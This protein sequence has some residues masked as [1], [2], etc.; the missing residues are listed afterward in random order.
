MNIAFLDLIECEIGLPGDI[1]VYRFTG[2]A[3]DEIAVQVN[4]TGGSAAT[5][6]F[7]VRGPGVQGFR[8]NCIPGFLQGPVQRRGFD[9]PHS[10]TYEIRVWESTA[11]GTMAYRLYLD[12]THPPAAPQPV[13][14]NTPVQGRIVHGADVSYFVFTGRAGA[15]IVAQA[16][17]T[18]GEGASPCFELR[19]PGN[20]SLR[21]PC[22]P[23]SGS[24]ASRRFE[25]RLSESG[26][27][28][29]RVWEQN[30]RSPMEYSLL[31]QCFGGCPEDRTQ[32]P[33]Q[34]PFTL[35]WNHPWLGYGHDFGE[36]EWGHDGMITS[37]WTYQVFPDSR[38]ITDTRAVERGGCSGTGILRA[39]LEMRG[40]QPGVDRGEVFL[41]LVNHPPETG[42]YAE[43]AQSLNLD[44][45]RITMRLRLP[46]GSAGSGSAPNGIQF[47]F[48]T[49][50]TDEDYPSLYSPW[51]NV[52][53]AWPGTCVDVSY[54]LTATSAGERTP[55]FDP[56][57]VRLI[58]FKIGVNSQSGA[59]IRGAVDI[60]SFRI[61][62]PPP[63]LPVIWDFEELEI[64]KD[65]RAA[66]ELLAGVDLSVV[67]IFTLADG[68]AAP[69]FNAGAASGF[70]RT[71]FDDFDALLTV[72]ARR[73]VRVMPVLLDFNWFTRPRT[74]SRAQLGGHSD[75]I[76]DPVKLQGFL[77]RV[78][79]PLLERY[80]SNPWIYAW[81][82]VN[83][84]EWVMAGVVQPP[85]SWLD[86]DPVTMDQMREFVRQCAQRIHQ[87]TPHKV[88]V[89][90]ARFRWLNLWKGLGLDFYQAHWYDHF[91]AEEPLP[92]M[93][94]RELNLDKPVIIGEV[95]TASTSVTG[96]QFVD[97]AITAGAE[98]LLFWSFRASDEYSGLRA[99]VETLRPRIPSVS[100]RG[101]V[102]AASFLPG[103]VAPLSWTTVFG[104]NLAP[105][106]CRAGTQPAPAA[107]C[108]VE[109]EIADSTGARHLAPLALVTGQQI[110]FLA[111]A[112][113]RNGAATLTVLRPEGFKATV[114]IRVE[115][116]SPGLFTV[117]PGGLAAAFA[118]RV[119]GELQ[120]VEPVFT[121]GAAGSCAPAPI[122]LASESDQVYLALFGTGIRRGSS[123]AIVSIGGAAATVMFAGAQG[124]DEGV[125]QVNVL[126]PRVLRGRGDVEVVL[127]VEG[128]Q[129]NPVRIAIR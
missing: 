33:V 53:P 95:P 5:P 26:S 38:G 88:T 128:N 46:A 41:D 67:R 27:H 37:G 98:A 113:L 125:D 96:A 119:S 31:V 83:E 93:S 2:A 70:D 106:S 20:E 58:G 85:P 76:R 52:D 60:E 22:V 39:A 63:R 3:G 99:A 34:R 54:T 56:G 8:S 10:G 92:W 15:S 9:L 68:R 100:A 4:R 64:E 87:I 57:R 122:D 28:A 30:V 66:K 82:V 114:P 44:G 59:E 91:R 104:A 42:P 90:S 123:S 65:F 129:S 77:D 121:C 40:R 107:L 117:N 6:C 112:G 118:I 80:K 50:R 111:P 108:G 127:S 72:A 14:F 75:V 61:D 69:E 13:P 36:N 81:D 21:G 1:D 43:P 79:T 120:T 29:L 12:R 23:G 25:Y 116:V 105:I 16:T 35:G 86:A 97:E 94:V 45:A 74:V 32:P 73:G 103:A 84:P 110:N 78:L 11:S 18:G 55:G 89:G 102:N 101:V 49:R 126:I 47:L 115:N 71:F 7:E 124:G 48:K 24:P 109:V 17:R 51:Q 19:G 62:F